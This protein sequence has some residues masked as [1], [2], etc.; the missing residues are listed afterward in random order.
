VV[1]ELGT[2]DDPEHYKAILRGEIPLD[3]DDEGLQP[4]TIAVTMASVYAEFRTRLAEY[5]TELA[6]RYFAQLGRASD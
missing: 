6:R 2:V 1:K 3:E 4:V 5:E